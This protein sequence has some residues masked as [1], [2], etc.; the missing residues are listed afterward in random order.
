MLNPKLYTVKSN[1]MNVL[2]Y[3]QGPEFLRTKFCGGVAL[4]EQSQPADLRAYAA[5]RQEI[6]THRLLPGTQLVELDLSTRLGFSRTPIRSGLKRLAYEG[7]V[8]YRHNRG[9]IVAQPSA[10]EVQEVFWLRER[11]E[12][13]AA[14][15][16]AR[17]ITAAGLDDLEQLILTEDIAFTRRDMPGIQSVS[18]Q[19]HEGIAA[20]SGN[21]FLHRLVLELNQRTSIYVAFYDIFRTD[22]PASPQEHRRVLAALRIADPERARLAMEEHIRNTFTALILPFSDPILLP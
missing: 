22:S 18:L 1:Y 15:E 6:M 2:E 10:G 11:A 21:R 3:L 7:L 9:H 20:A 5:I 12:G 17:R 13:M 8:Q 14:A 19:F 4:R 16:A